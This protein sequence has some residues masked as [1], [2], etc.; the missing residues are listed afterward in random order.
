MGDGLGQG[1]PPRRCGADSQHSLT[2]GRSWDV[3]FVITIGCARQFDET[4]PLAEAWL[5]E[6]SRK[7]RD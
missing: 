4:K 2:D 5:Q 7:Q 6:H 1:S 3:V